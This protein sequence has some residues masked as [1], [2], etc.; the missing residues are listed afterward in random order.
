VD[1]L[2]KAQYR[3]RMAADAAASTPVAQLASVEPIS[4]PLI[5]EDPNCGW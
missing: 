2:K 5:A 3:R 4:D 1:L